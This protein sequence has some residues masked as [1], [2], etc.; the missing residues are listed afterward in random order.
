MKFLFFIDFPMLQSRIGFFFHY[1]LFPLSVEFPHPLLLELY[2]FC[3]LMAEGVGT[4]LCL[5]TAVLMCGFFV[6]G[7][8]AILL[9]GFFVLR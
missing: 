6:R 3:V 1:I 8:C 9:W 2:V 4:C 5:N 7:N